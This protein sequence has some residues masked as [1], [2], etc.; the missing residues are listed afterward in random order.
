MSEKNPAPDYPAGQIRDR[1][2][3]ER[4]LLAWVRTSLALMAFGLGL[5]R[6]SL[7]LHVSALQVEGA[8]E[9]LPD[10]AISR[11]FGGALIFL[12][13]L[14]ALVGAW[15]TRIYARIIDPEDKA[16]ADTPLGVTAVLTAS[17][18]LPLLAYTLFF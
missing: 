4:T 7:I 5:D 15:R 3:N 16:P 1:L 9:L 8:A 12:G 18:S 13:G 17:L 11:W 10:P 2:A 6:F 14:A